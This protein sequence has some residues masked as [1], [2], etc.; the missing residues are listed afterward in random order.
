MKEIKSGVKYYYIKLKENH[1]DSDEIKVLESMKDGKL[2][3]LI[4]IKLMLRSLKNEGCLMFNNYIP[5]SPEMLSSIL[6]EPVG[7][8]KEAIDKFLKIGLITIKDNGEM[9]LDNIQD[10]IGRSSNEGERKKIYRQ[11]IKNENLLIE[12][13]K[14]EVEI[15]EEKIVDK[16]LQK[17]KEDLL[18]IINKILNDKNVNVFSENEKL[19]IKDWIDFRTKEYKTKKTEQAVKV[20]INNFIEIKDRLDQSVEISE[21]I[22]YVKENKTWQNITVDYLVSAKLL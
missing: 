9:W 6:N 22:N 7:V 3:S 2:Y 11:R 15:V 5:Y 13:K 18:D 20:Q 16:K 8:I 21:V 1:F 4:Y 17:E 14:E 19:S 12:E 10:S